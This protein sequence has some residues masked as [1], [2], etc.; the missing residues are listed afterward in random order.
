MDDS[1][2]VP[3]KKRDYMQ[4]LD[5]I[6][7]IGDEDK[8]VQG[9]MRVAQSELFEKHKGANAALYGDLGY[10]IMIATA[11]ECAKVFAL[12][13]RQGSQLQPLVE[14]FEVRSNQM[15]SF[16]LLCT[17]GDTTVGL[18]KCICSITMAQLRLV[19]WCR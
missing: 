1:I 14:Q 7:V 16:G 4:F 11:G 18:V 19:C 17:V 15:L 12:D 8:P 10:I 6:L 2:T 13:V 3:D 5:K 9:E